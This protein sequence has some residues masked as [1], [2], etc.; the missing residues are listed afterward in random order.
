MTGSPNICG[1]SI[2]A[3]EGAYDFPS[4]VRFGLR[5]RHDVHR[6]PNVGVF[7]LMWLSVFVWFVPWPLAVCVIVA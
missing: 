2:R 6:Y 5:S 4:R 7:W 1:T 3:S